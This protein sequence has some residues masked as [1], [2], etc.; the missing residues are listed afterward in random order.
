MSDPVMVLCVDGPSRGRLRAVTGGERIRFHVYDYRPIAV[1][2][3]GDDRK[4]LNADTLTYHVHQ[5]FLLGFITRIAS[6]H[7]NQDDINPYDIIETLFSEPARQA[8]Y[9]S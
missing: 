9:R 1:T 5:I 6:I 2:L 3:L 8:T 7:I 4:E